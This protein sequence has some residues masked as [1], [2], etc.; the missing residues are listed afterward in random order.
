MVALLLVSFHAAIQPLALQRCQLRPGQT[1]HVRTLRM[2]DRFVQQ[3]HKRTVQ[4][5]ETAG[6]CAASNGP[7]LQ[8]WTIRQV[9]QSMVAG[10]KGWR[11][12]HDGYEWVPKNICEWDGMWLEEFEMDNVV[13]NTICGMLAAATIQVE[14]AGKLA[15]RAQPSS[16]SST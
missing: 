16:S 7:W 1:Q 14:E 10:L 12:T 13:N 11:Q 9:L 3:N 5:L 2:V 4:A 15:P 8:L 6:G